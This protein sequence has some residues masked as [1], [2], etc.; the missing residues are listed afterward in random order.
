MGQSDSKS[1]EAVQWYYRPWVVLILLF[2]VLG[3]LGLPLVYKS[4]KLNRAWKILLTLVMLAY[5]AYLV[6]VT[7]AFVKTVSSQ[8]SVLTQ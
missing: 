7:T 2:F 8:L 3:P 6:F 4:P 5:T 1:E